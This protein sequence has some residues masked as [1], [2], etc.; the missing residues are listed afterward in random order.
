[1]KRRIIALFIAVFALSNLCFMNMPARAEVIHENDLE[2]YILKELKETHVLS[3]GISIVSPERE[4]YCA[5][6]GNQTD[7]EAKYVLGELTQS[8]TA[9]AVLQLAEDSEL[10][11]DD[12]VGDYLPAYKEVANVTIRELLNQT[13]GISKYETMSKI[14]RSGTPGTYE[15]APVN[16]NLLGKIIEAVSEV[17][18]QEY[19]SDNILDPLEMQSYDRE[20]D[21]PVSG[22]RSYFGFPFYED[23]DYDIKDEW[24]QMSSG[25][26]V[27][28]VKDMGKYLQ[29]FLQ[30]G[31]DVLSEE[32]ISTMLENTVPVPVSSEETTEIFNGNAAYGMGWLTKEF[33]GKK[34]YYHIGKTNNSTTAMFLLPEKN[35]GI[36]LAFPSSNSFVGEDLTWKLAKG[37][38]AIELEET[39]EQFS[40]DD[41]LK[42]CVTMDII[43][44]LIVLAA[45]LPIFLMGFWTKRR[46]NHVFSV[47]GI[48][49]DLVIHVALPTAFFVVVP[50][51]I[52]WFA[53]KREHVE[54]FY[55][56]VI[57][58]ASLYFGALIKL[59]SMIVYL[60]LGPKEET[61]EKQESMEEIFEK[62]DELS[63]KAKEI[64]G[65]GKK[66][67]AGEN[68]TNV[69]VTA[70]QTEKKKE[71]VSEASKQPDKKEAE[72][73][74]SEAEK[75]GKKENK[76]DNTSE[77]EKKA[78][79]EESKKPKTID[80]K[81][82]AKRKAAGEK[83][84]GSSKED[85]KQ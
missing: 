21:G 29:M 18:Y 8:L 41:Y 84:S 30:R 24:I 77:N 27:S 85:K 12:P 37:I 64:T 65:G 31:G 25:Y 67:Q 17:T 61:E 13:S 73:K 3:M 79:E 80:E 19:I 50:Q 42:D 71:D 56:I 59:I 44:V 47:I 46:R 40:S 58:I 52:P 62:A 81:I 26:A 14:T 76:E 75:S 49:I 82:E 1:M 83:E 22:Y 35:F 10:H 48:L 54:I 51:E 7:T 5:A 57:V 20:S 45:W 33:N 4:L 23:S 16:Y 43:Y 70:P 78:V 15:A 28:S 11:L 39:P 32:S 53:L 55:V 9:A 74:D 66:T 36:T 38:L 60:I 69:P 63:E 68:G 34:I 6:Y 72:A 2:K